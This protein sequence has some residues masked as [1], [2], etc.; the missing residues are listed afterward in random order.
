[1][2]L[3]FMDASRVIASLISNLKFDFCVELRSRYFLDY[4]W[5]IDYMGAGLYLILGF[6]P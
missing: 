3:L 4:F 1:M 5:V 2:M 6:E